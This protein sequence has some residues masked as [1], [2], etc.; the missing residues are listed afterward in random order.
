[1]KE[2]GKHLPGRHYTISKCVSVVTAI[3]L[4]REKVT[5]YDA[6]DVRLPTTVIKNAKQHIGH[7]TS[8]SASK[9]N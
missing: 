4:Q 2:T 9:L 6:D 7:C 5:Y 3:D 8:D 1:M